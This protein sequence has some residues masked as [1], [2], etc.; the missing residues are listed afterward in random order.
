MPAQ[1]GPASPLNAIAKCQSCL[2]DALEGERRRTDEP[3]HDASYCWCYAVEMGDRSSVEELVL[4]A[5]S[6]K[7]SIEQC[8]GMTYGYFLLGDYNSG[9]L[10]P[11][12]DRRVS[13]AS[14]R[15]EGI[16]WEHR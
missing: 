5:F 11:H 2:R 8:R 14:N 9:V 3:G 13:G 7:S 15:L 6:M 1:L 16:F 10:P 4:K 12:R